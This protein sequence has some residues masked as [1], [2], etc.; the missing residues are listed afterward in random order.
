MNK[1]KEL[2]KIAKGIGNCEECKKDKIGKAVP[3]EGNQDADI[4]FLGEAPGKTEAKTGRPFVGRSGKL[5]R[6]LI[7]E[8]GL[9]EENVFITSP[10]KRLPIYGTPK[11]SDI[12]H[13]KT[14][15]QKQLDVIQ[16]KIIVLLGSVAAKAVLSKLVFPL[17]HHGTIVEEKGIKYFITIHPAAGLRFPPLKKL[18]KEDFKYL[19][20]II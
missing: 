7:N 3:G 11:M 9:K 12:K 14:H 10:V 17:K 20:R 19:N 2:L 18:I 4:V 15:L 13:G 5:L 16:P 1:Q 6:S 8:V